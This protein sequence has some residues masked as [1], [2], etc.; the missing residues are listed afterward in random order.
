MRKL[1]RLTAVA[2]ACAV[3]TVVPQ[4]EVIEDF[5]D[6]NISEYTF[7]GDVQA[8]VTNYAAHD[9][10]YGLV[11]AGH[12]GAEGWMYRNDSQVQV[13]QGDVIGFW[14][15][16]MPVTDNYTRNY[17]GFG[18]S[19]AGCY[20]AVL[21]PNTST[22]ILQLNSGYGYATLADAPQSWQLGHWYYTEVTW[23]AGGLIVADLYDADG[24]TLLNSVSAT[25]NTFTSGGIAMRSFDSGHE[26][27]FDTITRNG[28]PTPAG[29]QTWGAIKSMFR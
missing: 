25:N 3:I 11:I 1:L 7:I 16:T 28:G 5:E 9:G 4:A 26:A 21:A 22:F 13:G 20:S 19:A 24:V 10:N 8:Y 18:A 14:S 17:Q 29:E 27:Y 23:H 15:R 12:A 2:F 6:G